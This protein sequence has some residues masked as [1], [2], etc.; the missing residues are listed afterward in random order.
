MM[1]VLGILNIAYKRLKLYLEELIVQKPQTAPL[2]GSPT[3][4][5]YDLLFSKTSL[6]AKGETIEVIQKDKELA[7][8][9]CCIFC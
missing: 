2:F 3:D 5:P 7:F 1:N 4:F 9:M 8:L 6:R